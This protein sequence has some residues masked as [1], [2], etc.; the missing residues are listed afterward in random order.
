MPDHPDCPADTGQ[1]GGFLLCYRANGR[2]IFWLHDENLENSDD[3]PPPNRAAE[4]IMGDLPAALGQLEEIAGD[5][6]TDANY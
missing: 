5:L 2:D 6:G 3:L 4:E 1:R